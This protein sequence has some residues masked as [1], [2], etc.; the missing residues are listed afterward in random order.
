MG[1]LVQ[2]LYFP[3][4]PHVDAARSV[5]AQ[6]LSRLEHPPGVAEVDVTDIRTPDHLR[7]WGSP[8]ILVDGVDVGG[9]VASGLCCRLYADF[10]S[11]GAPSVALVEAALRRT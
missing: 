4:C 5:L 11:S 7:R 1:V 3:G 10:E 8:T 6:A 2:L 9:G